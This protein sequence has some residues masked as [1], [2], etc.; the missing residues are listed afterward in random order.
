MDVVARQVC[1]AAGSDVGI[2]GDG[3]EKFAGI[4][5]GDIISREYFSPEA[6]GSA[7]REV[8]SFPQF[9]RADQTTNVFPAEFDIPR[10]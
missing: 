1:A 4:L 7:Y 6:G 10:L 3:A 8:V 2:D 5:R 9:E